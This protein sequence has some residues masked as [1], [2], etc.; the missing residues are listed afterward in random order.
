MRRWVA[1]L[2]EIEENPLVLGFEEQD[3][4]LARVL[5]E[6]NRDFA[7][8]LRAPLTTTGSLPEFTG[9]LEDLS[10]AYPLARRL[11]EEFHPLSVRMAGA[12]GE[13]T[14]P[15]EPE[16]PAP[17]SAPRPFAAERETEP[18]E[19]P[20]F[21]LAAELL[22]RARKED[23]LLV[24]E[25]GDPVV[26]RLANALFLV[27]C[28]TMQRWTERQCE[29][30]RLYR[31]LRRQREVAEALGVT[32]QS[33]SSSLS[34]AGWKSM[35]E[36]ESVLRQVLARPAAETPDRSSLLPPRHDAPTMKR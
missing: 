24:I 33:V 20:A 4:R 7:A 8:D 35:E 5:G 2:G 17:G 13:V 9:V 6:L 11:A 18:F 1:V 29:V 34:A 26:D 23:R 31:T 22:Y 15:G 30:V 25:G 10:S 19:G 12:V 28:R 14:V 36:V 27:L 21:D 3:A 16:T 32:Q